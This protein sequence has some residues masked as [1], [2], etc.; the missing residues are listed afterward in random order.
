MPLTSS[1]FLRMALNRVVS[2]S[3]FFARSECPVWAPFR[4]SFVFV[5]AIRVGKTFSLGPVPDMKSYVAEREREGRRVI[6]REQEES[7]VKQASEALE[8]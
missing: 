4:R 8:C 6:S 1:T 2:A 3:R 5:S 7:T